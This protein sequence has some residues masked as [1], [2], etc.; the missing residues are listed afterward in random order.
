MVSK[1]DF[2]PGAGDTAQ[3]RTSSVTFVLSKQLAANIYDKV[4]P[5]AYLEIIGTLDAAKAADGSPLITGCR[6]C[7]LCDSLA[8]VAR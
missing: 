5:A 7:A 2:K 3:L 8:P 1:D 6:I 4:A